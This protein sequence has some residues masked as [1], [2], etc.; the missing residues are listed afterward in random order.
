MTD[1]YYKLILVIRPIKAIVSDMVSLLEKIHTALATWYVVNDLTK[2]FIPAP[3]KK[4]LY[5]Y[6]RNNNLP[7][8]Y[9]SMVV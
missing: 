3:N 2:N 6:S 4:S 8:W 5:S 9:Y 1:D 7:L